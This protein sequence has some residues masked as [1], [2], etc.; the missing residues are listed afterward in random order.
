MNGAGM[1]GAPAADMAKPRDE[2]NEA[3]CALLAKYLAEAKHGRWRFVAIVTVDGEG[4]IANDFKG[5]IRSIPDGNTGL[6]ILK[7]NLL[8]ELIRQS[9]AP[10]PGIVPVTALPPAIEGR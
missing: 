8:M 9:R 1:N 7:G 4:G 5:A 6:D 2:A 3:V 10:A